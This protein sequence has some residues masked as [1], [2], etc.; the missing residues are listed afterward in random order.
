V[1]TLEWLDQLAQPIICASMAGA[2]DGNLARA[3]SAAGGLGTIGFSA[4]A[5]TDHVAAQCAVPQAAALPFGVGFNC[6]ALDQ[7]AAVLDAAVACSPVLISL[8]FGDPTPYVRRARSGGASVASQVGTLD[9]ARRAIDAG[10]DALIARGSEGGGHGRGEVATLPLLQQLVQSGDVPVIAAGGIAT[11]RGVAAVLAAGAIAVW[12]GT[13]FAACAESCFAI[14]LKQ[15]VLD[16]GSDDTVYTRIFDIAQQIP[17]P[18]EYG[19]RA[20]VNRFSDRWAERPEELAAEVA[21]QPQMT[22]EMNQAR[23]DARLDIAPVY[24]G[25]SAGL[26]TE[27]LTAADVIAELA[28]FRDH[29]G[30]AANRWPGERS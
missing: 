8:S 19:G 23:Q 1:V 27:R 11:G 17:W 3:V 14:P 9:E 5:T 16:A 24:A 4:S 26:V 12:V 2:A 22:A 18:R 15:A 7:D 10:V 6:W 28:T 13:P 21:R 30:A 25:Q 20:L 29:L